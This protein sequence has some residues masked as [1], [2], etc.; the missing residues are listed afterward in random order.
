MPPRAVVQT[1]WSRSQNT[2][3]AVHVG[4]ALPFWAINL[5]PLVRKPRRCARM[6]TDAS[7]AGRLVARARYVFR[8]P[9][10]V[11]VNT[12]RC[13]LENSVR[14]RGEKLP[15]V[16]DEEHRA[17]EGRERFHQHLFGR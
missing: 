5:S 17:L 3:F 13:K 10:A 4:C 14:Q 16:R 15:I 9:T 2:D 1:L 7:D 11:E 12:V 8:V 6:G